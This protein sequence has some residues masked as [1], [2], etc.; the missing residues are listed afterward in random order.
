M[1]WVCLIVKTILISDLKHA[2]GA[3]R[4]SADRNA[5]G[6]SPPA[7]GSAFNAQ[8]NIKCT[9]C[10]RHDRMAKIVGYLTGVKYNISL[11]GVG[12]VGGMCGY[13]V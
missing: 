6:K 10:E 4:G 11:G 8:L 5:Y 12:G 13:L 9:V 7:L 2:H 1:A 3:P